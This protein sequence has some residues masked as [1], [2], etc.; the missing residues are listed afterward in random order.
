MARLLRSLKRR[1]NPPSDETTRMA[2]LTPDSKPVG[3]VLLSYAT[4]V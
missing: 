2:E 1:L 3:R 4:R